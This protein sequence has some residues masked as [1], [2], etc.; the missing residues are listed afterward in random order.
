[1]RLRMEA[2]YHLFIKLAFRYPL[3]VVGV[4]LLGVIFS[5]WLSATHLA[6]HTSHLDL[7]SSGDRYKQLDQTFSREFEDVPEQVIVVIRSQDR[8]R[9]KGFASALSKGWEGDSNIDKVLYRIPLDALQDKAL[10]YLSAT[11]L[12]DLQQQLEQH[13]EFFAEFAEHPTLEH[14]FTLVNR[15]ITRALV[16]HVFTDFLVEG[17][18]AEEPLDLSFLLAMLRQLNQHLNPQQPYTS[19]WQTVF[20][21]RSEAACA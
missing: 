14:L 6:F 20:T 5:L 4:A 10:W 18:S 2:F 13:Q 1:M 3:V 8:D 21:S 19:L 9:A 16:R 12:G 15:E 7:V 17:P 11:E